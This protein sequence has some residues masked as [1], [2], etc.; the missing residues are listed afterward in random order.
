MSE[1]TDR[2]FS[3]LDRQLTEARAAA[4]GVATR[5]G[6][7]TSASALAAGLVGSRLSSIAHS[8]WTV[9]TLVAFGL[10]ALFGIVAVAPLTL[11]GMKAS[12]LTAWI[13]SV[14]AAANP[15]STVKD[16]FDKKV[17]IL[18][19]NIT[20]LNII[21]TMYYS[22]SVT[23]VVAIVLAVVAVEATP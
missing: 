19:K 3:E 18:E 7:L 9:A 21:R 23:V 4:D 1:T 11:V 20:I 2:L 5:A 14:G 13:G 8:G 10:A 6:F 12:V 16:I 15:E 22:Q 17:V